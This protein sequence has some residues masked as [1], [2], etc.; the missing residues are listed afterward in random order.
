ML[1][2]LEDRIRELCAQAVASSISSGFNE[3][4][5]ELQSALHEH[6]KRLRKRFL[7]PIVPERRQKPP[8]APS[9]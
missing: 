7:S 2:R 5:H 3:V 4:I 1:N 8:D 9:A 6:T